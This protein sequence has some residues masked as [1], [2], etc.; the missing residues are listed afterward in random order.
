MAL[1]QQTPQPFQQQQLGFCVKVLYR[2]TLQQPVTLT[3]GRV[4]TRFGSSLTIG[5][6]STAMCPPSLTP[7]AGGPSAASSDWKS[8]LPTVVLFACVRAR[9]GEARTRTGSGMWVSHLQPF[10]RVVVGSSPCLIAKLAS[11]SRFN[12]SFSPSRRCLI[13][14]LLHTTVD[15][16]GDYFTCESSVRS[17]CNMLW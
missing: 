12:F 13:S 9:R 10:A 1:A 14:G 6:R 11:I 15:D 17:R 7:A 5:A 2:Y 8:V 4:C 16:I 3:T